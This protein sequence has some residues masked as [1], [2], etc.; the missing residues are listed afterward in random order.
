M[1]ESIIVMVSPRHKSQRPP[2]ANIVCLEPLIF[3][4]RAL[5]ERAHC[6]IAIGVNF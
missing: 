3:E 5:P 6:E 2:L 1:K 4:L